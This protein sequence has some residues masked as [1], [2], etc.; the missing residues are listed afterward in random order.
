M[1]A[2]VLFGQIALVTGATG[3]IGKA[4]CRALASHGS[5]IV[6]H[7]YSDEEEARSLAR[8]LEAE[9]QGKLGINVLCARADMGDY[10]EVRKLHAYLV[11]NLGYPTIPINNARTNGGYSGIVSIDQVHMEDF[12]RTWR[13]NCGSAYLLTQL[14]M[15]AME[16]EG[17]GR[18][19]FISSVAGFTG[20]VVGPHY[21][22]SKS[23]L[24]GLVHWLA[25]AYAKKG[26]TVNGVAP[27]LI[28]R[29]KMLP[30]STKV[31]AS[32]IPLGRLGAPEEVA[33]TVI[34]M[35]KTPYVTNKVIGVDG[36]MF[37]Q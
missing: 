2:P 14:C 4:I 35:V 29:T 30:G 25:Q 10:N 32:K 3:G 6:I 9:Y 1:S 8:E 18:I 22:S 20:G 16:S 19:I 27:A 13:I 28:E 34:W 36:G 12:E 5:S 17:W 11:E 21:A 7:Y 26:I 37:P 24:H 23:A 33:E 31:L 15:P